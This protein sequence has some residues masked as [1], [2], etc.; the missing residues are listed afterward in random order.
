MDQKVEQILLAYYENGAKKLR[1]TINKIFVRYYGGTTGKDIEEFYGV[2]TDV[3]MEI[4]YKYKHEKS[5]YD[6]SKGDLDGYVYNSL[7]KAIID[8]YKT[9]NRDKRTAKTFL[10][11]ENGNKVLD[12]KTGKP[13]KIPISD[14]RLD[15]PVKGE[16]GITY[17]DII[18]SDF[19]IE[20]IIFQKG[21]YQ[22]EKIN[23]YLNSLHKIARQ[24]IEMKMND[25][26]VSEIK[27][28]LHLSDKEYS[29]Y[30]NSAKMNENIAL[31]TKQSNRYK[32]EKK[33]SNIIPIDVTDNYRM[34]KFPLGSL[35][36]DMNEGK[37]NKRHI[38]QRKAFQWTERQ[39]N[40]YLTRVLNGQPIPE[41]V[42]CEQFIKGKKKSHLIDGLQRLSYSELFRADG[43]V[44]K[45]DG[46]EFYEIPYK[47]YKYDSDG[48]ILLDEDGDALFEEK[49]F[50]VLGKKFSDFPQ[51]LK[52]RFNKFNINVTTYF[53]CTDD[54]IAYHIRNYNNQEG[55]N[56]NQYEF[57]GVNA[58]IAERI[59]SISD[60][61]SFFKDTCGKY[62]EK[63]KIKGDLDKVV[64]ESIMA[65]NFINDWKKDVKDSFAFVNNN[66]TDYMFDSFEDSLDRLS[67]IIDK[68][69]KGIFTVVN[70][71][72]W[73][74]VFDKFKRLNDSDGKFKEFVKYVMNSMDNLKVDKKSFAD[75]YK[76]R[77]TRDKATIVKKVNGLTTLMYGFLHINPEAKINSDSMASNESFI[78]DVLNMDLDKVTEEME[79]YNET[80]DSLTDKAIK[81][82]SRLLDK[83]NRKSLLALVAYSYKQDVDLDE[84]LEQYAE[85]N[86]MYLLDQ[87]KNYLHMRSDFEKYISTKTKIIA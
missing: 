38:L 51:F 75:I 71:P 82:G 17:S 32:E 60:E 40:K 86:S 59:K 68:E 50:N 79:V 77:N 74:A 53:N 35:L 29:N 8:E 69:V 1:N 9:Q 57:T 65:I 26:P 80:L 3:L 78:A 45:I 21:D 73:F 58:H 44:I 5:T 70:S 7:R 81:D 19:S 76:S 34:D 56:K 41:I 10:L 11:D 23:K 24:I 85:K 87:R 16:E 42:I 25:I 6:P 72:V 33:M 84:W 61:H 62:T 39:K 22:D 20:D 4:W 2:G 52:D 49:I 48:N 83:E 67:K 47:E 64:V 54:Q 13:I 12:E 27:K 31:F 36:D 63:N 55:M 37:I 46:A 43:I 30:M 18:Q 66:A 14:I 28:K 15:S